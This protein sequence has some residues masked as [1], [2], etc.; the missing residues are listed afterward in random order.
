MLEITRQ[1][2]LEGGGGME[3]SVECPVCDNIEDLTLDRFDLDLN[4]FQHD[5]RV[6]NLK[7][8]CS[9]CQQDYAFNIEIDISTL[10]FPDES[11]I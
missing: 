4:D 1:Y 9:M 2:S 7:N 5:S 8:T 6:E 11:Y 10:A 3:F